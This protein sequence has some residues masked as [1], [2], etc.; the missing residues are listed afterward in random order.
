MLWFLERQTSATTTN[1]PTDRPTTTSTNRETVSWLYF[2]VRCVNGRTLSRRCARPSVRASICPSIHSPSYSTSSSWWGPASLITISPSTF[3][4]SFSSFTKTDLSYEN[5][6]RVVKPLF[7]LFFL[8]YFPSFFFHPL[9]QPNPNPLLSW[10]EL[11]EKERETNKN[12]R[13]RSGPPIGGS[14]RP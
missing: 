10:A 4:F 2:R 3:S 1:R 11:R 12:L 5:V 8:F 9:H 6:L 14:V 7:F 13:G